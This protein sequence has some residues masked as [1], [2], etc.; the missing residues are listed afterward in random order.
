MA[1]ILNAIFRYLM[2]V[3][4]IFTAPFKFFFNLRV[5]SE[6]MAQVR[7]NADEGMNGILPPPFPFRVSLQNSPEYCT[8]ESTHI[9]NVFLTFPCLVYDTA[10]F[11]PWCDMKFFWAHFFY[12]KMFWTHFFYSTVFSSI[13]S[14]CARFL[15]SH[16]H[17]NKETNR[18]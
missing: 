12:S 18:K 3:I 8:E 10:N 17:N 14:L 9:E 13:F 16:L 15:C 7:F 2:G 5:S 4:F 6:Q 11:P 1:W